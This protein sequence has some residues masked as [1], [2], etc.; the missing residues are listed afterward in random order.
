MLAVGKELGHFNKGVVTFEK[1]L[2]KI[3]TNHKEK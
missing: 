2:K 3:A 1:E